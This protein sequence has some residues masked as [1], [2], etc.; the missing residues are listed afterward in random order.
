MS[1]SVRRSEAPLILTLGSAGILPA[2]PRASRPRLCG[3]DAP[4]TAAGT[5]ALQNHYLRITVFAELILSKRSYTRT[6][7]TCSAESFAGSGNAG[8]P[9][10]GTATW[11][12]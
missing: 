10:T 11:K 1:S 12:S 8:V 6:T 7:T 5:A 9:P 2:V 3:R 4:T